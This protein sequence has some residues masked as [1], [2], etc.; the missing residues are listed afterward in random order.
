MQCPLRPNALVFGFA[1]QTPP[2]PH[3]S[4]SHPSDLY[5]PPLPGRLQPFRA[6]KGAGRG[7]QKWW[8]LEEKSRGFVP[9]IPCRSA[10]LLSSSQMPAASYA[11]QMH[12]RDVWEAPTFQKGDA[13]MLLSRGRGRPSWE[14]T[15]SSTSLQV[16]QG[17]TAKAMHSSLCSKNSGIGQRFTEPRTL[18]LTHALASTTQI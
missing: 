3:S 2:P 12:Q 16:E 10:R 6:C 17:T 18:A 7:A 11:H 5:S 8:P 15:F 14:A 1:S 13:S 9:R 4:N